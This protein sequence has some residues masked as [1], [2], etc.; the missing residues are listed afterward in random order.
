MGLW[1]AVACSE[2]LGTRRENPT[3]DGFTAQVTLYCD[4]VDR[5]DLV[6]D[7]LFVG[8]AWPEF[9]SW[10]SPPLAQ[11]CSITGVQG[12]DLS[13]SGQEI[14]YEVAEVQVSYGFDRSV[15][16]VAESIESTA[17]FSQL[18]YRNFAWGSA[19]GDPLSEQETPGRQL[20]GLALSRTI[21]KMSLV[22]SV[23]L[24]AGSVNNAPYTSPILGLTFAEESLMLTPSKI[25]RTIRTDGSTPYNVSMK[26]LYRKEGWNK[27]WRATTMAY[28]AIYV[29]GGA[30][31][32]NY[33]PVDMSLILF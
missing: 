7:L 27:Y 14:V 17:Q 18:D 19:N 28:D 1:S 24:E 8:R 30:E 15:D 12:G 16:L 23:I 11:S 20:R 9:S 10:E 25:S 3:L 4:W 22:P 29:R 33:P 13:V 5:W 21:Y 6:D 2:K 26:L 32:K 31:Y